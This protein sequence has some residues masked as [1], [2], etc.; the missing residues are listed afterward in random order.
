MEKP[1]RGSID[2]MLFFVTVLLVAIGITMCYSA[3]AILA[4]EHFD[5]AYYFLKKTAIFTVVGFIFML[6]ATNIPYIYYKKFVYP[7]LALFLLLTALVFVPGIGKSVGGA[8]R[9]IRIAFFNFQP[10]EML[11]IATIVFMAYSLEK[12]EK[13]LGEFGMGFAFHIVF[14]ILISSFVLVQRDFGSAMTIIATGMLMMMVAGIRWIYLA[15]WLVA[16]VPVAVWLI[17]AEPYR[18][19]RIV[20]FLNPWQDQYGAGFQVIQSLIAFNQGG[21]FGKGLGQ[22]QQKLFYLPEAHTDFIFSV[23]GEE[24]GLMGIVAIIALFGVFCYRG[25]SIAMK[26]T[27]VFAR[28]L[29]IGLTS[30]ICLEAV[31]NMGVVMALLPPKGMTLPLISYGGS[32]LISSLVVV[33]MILSVSIY[34]RGGN[35]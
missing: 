1:V 32:S 17:I 10:S 28:Y 26:S 35:V 2:Y 9:W 33:G 20:A 29:V 18:L 23:I 11:K 12:K 16:L 3:T 21:W 25:I 4:S 13:R 27:D 8:T 31:L 22:G 5:N 6:I 24:L 15:S 7:I 14:L 19:K 30:L 34:G